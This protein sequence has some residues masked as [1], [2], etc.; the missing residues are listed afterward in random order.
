[1][2]SSSDSK[3]GQPQS[4]DVIRPAFNK[5][6][7]QQEASVSS[8]SSDKRRHDSEETAQPATGQ[9]SAA[10]APSMDELNALFEGIGATPSKSDPPAGRS[11]SANAGASLGARLGTTS[12]N[13]AGTASSTTY[14]A[15]SAD[16]TGVRLGPSANSSSSKEK[17]YYIFTVGRPGSGKSTFQS[18]L[19]RYLMTQGHHR[20]EPDTE[21][22]ASEA[23][24]ETFAKWRAQW[25]SG[26]FPDRTAAGRPAEFRYKV[27]PHKRGYPTIPF[28]FVEISGEDFEKLMAFDQN[29]PE[30]LDSVDDFL[31]HP[32]IHLAFFFICQG[33][34]IEQDDNLFGRFLDY[35]A[36]HT[37]RPYA[38]NCSAALVLADPLACQRHLAKRLNEPKLRNRPLDIEK[39]VDEFTPECASRLAG[40]ENRATIA[41]FSV[42]QVETMA[43]A[44][45]EKKP[46]ISKP[47]FEDAEMI[48]NW[49]YRRFTGKRL[50][51]GFRQKTLKWLSG[52]TG[53]A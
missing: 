43:L 17:Y 24:R 2:P 27:T 25:Q 13:S 3:N 16:M 33:N 34:D 10:K 22:T 28:G 18:H 37:D 14:T 41:T 6:A 47:S 46:R 20:V 19:L 53:G 1:M 12:G 48:Y 31:N 45:A 29:M 23:F 38:E 44:N 4:A 51:Q 42:G 9:K 32:N 36:H 30:F 39:F 8:D 40:W 35:L 49:L 52:L 21:H 26:F 50:G 15:P 7:G 11:A 5:G